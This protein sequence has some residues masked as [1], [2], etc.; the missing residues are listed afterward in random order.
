MSGSA[1]LFRAAETKAATSS[2]GP[3]TMK[4]TAEPNRAQGIRGQRT[5]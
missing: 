5:E 4:R 3:S 2:S 1:P